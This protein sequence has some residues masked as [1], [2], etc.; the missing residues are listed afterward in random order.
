MTIDIPCNHCTK[1]LGY[2][3]EP[4]KNIEPYFQDASLM[5]FPRKTPAVPHLLGLHRLAPTRQGAKRTDQSE[6][7]GGR[8]R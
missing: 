8:C 2:S 4:T 5:F 1:D 3:I 6:T 7:A